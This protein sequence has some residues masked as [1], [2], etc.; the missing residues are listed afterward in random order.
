MNNIYVVA[1]NWFV[2]RCPLVTR[3]PRVPVGSTTFTILNRDKHGAPHGQPQFCETWQHPVRADR[4]RPELREHAHRSME[5]NREAYEY[6]GRHST[7]MPFEQSKMDAL[8]DLMGD[9]EFTSY[10]GTGEDPAIAGRPKQKGLRTLLPR[11]D[12]PINAERY[13]ATDFVRDTLQ[14]CRLRGGDPDVL[15]VSPNFMTGF[16]TWGSSPTRIDAGVNVFG[17]AI[18]VFEVPF[19]GSI[20]VIE[21]PLLKPFTAVCLT[22]NEVR[23]RMK[24]NEF[25]SPRGDA[26]EGDWMAE[27]AIE[28]DNPEH[29]AWVEGITEFVAC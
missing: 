12:C 2:N 8:Q 24:R 15:L 20:S 16:S 17:T 4:L 6:L 19:L 21:A 11:I 14:A 10:Y 22:S 3:V 7:K 29:H 25:W 23:M 27:G 5:H 18:D 1:S 26:Y 28:V 13:K 9:M